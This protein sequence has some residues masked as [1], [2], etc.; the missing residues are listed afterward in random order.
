MSWRC[1]LLIPCT[2]IFLVVRVWISILLYVI[3]Q[4]GH[5]LPIS[6]AWKFY[7][8]YIWSYTLIN[9]WKIQNILALKFE[10]FPYLYIELFVSNIGLKIVT[11]IKPSWTSTAFYNSY[12][13][14]LSNIKNYRKKIK[15]ITWIYFFGIGNRR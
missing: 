9:K 11:T 2:S 15:K 13:T 12:S 8:W 4:K 7:L 3:F 10:H 6:S 5:K 14:V 1:L